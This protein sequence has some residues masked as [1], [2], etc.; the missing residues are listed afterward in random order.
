MQVKGVSALGASDAPIADP[1]DRVA[2]VVLR[3]RL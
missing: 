2:A 3:D 1:V